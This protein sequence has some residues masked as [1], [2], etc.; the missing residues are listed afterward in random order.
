MQFDLFNISINE[1]M[2]IMLLITKKQISSR[3]RT[4]FDSH[5]FVKNVVITM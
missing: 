4:T 5:D 3:I 2:M 1:K